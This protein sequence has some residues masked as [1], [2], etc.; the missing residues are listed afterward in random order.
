LQQLGPATV[1]IT[2]GVQGALISTRTEQALIPAFKVTPVDSTAAGDI[3]C[4]SLAVALV[5]SQS[6]MDSVRFASA[7]A[8]IYVTR[9]GA[10]PSA[11]SRE[12]IDR[13]LAQAV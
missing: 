7:P 4:G 1:I 10:Q 6:V 12:E 9:L 5:E 2:L 8:A 13:F 11:P 3:F